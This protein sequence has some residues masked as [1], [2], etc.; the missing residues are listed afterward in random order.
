E[1]G[2]PPVRALLATVFEEG[3][4]RST[5]AVGLRIAQ[6]VEQSADETQ[7]KALSE[8]GLRAGAP[9][10][11]PRGVATVLL[12]CSRKPDSGPRNVLSGAPTAPGW[13][14]PCAASG[15][16]WPHEPGLAVTPADLEGAFR[17]LGCA[18]GGLRRSASVTWPAGCRTYGSN[19]SALTS[20]PAA[21][22]GQL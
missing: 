10:G 1:T 12:N 16:R 11:D 19:A 7:A 6:R 8:R 14:G 17:S 2:S 20:G 3:L 15:V 21:S 18:S 13:C 22:R 4:I 5:P 9:R